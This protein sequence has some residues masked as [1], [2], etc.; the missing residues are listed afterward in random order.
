MDVLTSRRIVLLGKSGAGKS[1]LANTILGEDV[2]KINHSPLPETSLSHAET[3]SVNGRSITFI[4][5]PGFFNA[6]SEEEMK[7]EIVRCTTEC[8]PGPHAFL[9]VLKV[10][11][12]TE[13]EQAVIAEICQSFSEDALKYA[14]MVFTHG[15][16]LPDGMKIDEYVGQNQNLSDLVKK[17]GGRCHVVD[18]RYW[19]TDKDK[20]YRSNQFQVAELLNTLDRMIEANNGSYYTNDMLQEVKRKIQREEE[21]IRQ[22]SENMSQG[23]IRNK[24]K[25]CIFDWLLIR[26][27]GIL[28]S[29]LLEALLGVPLALVTGGAVKSAALSGVLK[30]ILRGYDAAEGAE[31]PGEA[32][33]KAVEGFRKQFGGAADKNNK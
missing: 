3:K 11:K 21:R 31:S 33:Q 14:V 5:T 17:C 6:R 7:P 16:Q 8:A 27:A 1:S 24:A 13:Q 28:T 26:S 22:T 30:G 19:K 12:F 4:D 25:I 2:F 10:E 15:D 29:V 23:E 18:N 32:V 20:N 9:I